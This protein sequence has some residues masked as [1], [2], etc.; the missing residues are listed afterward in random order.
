M[1]IALELDEVKKVIHLNITTLH[2]LLHVNH[3]IN[4]RWA[5]TISGDGLYCLCHNNFGMVSFCIVGLHDELFQLCYSIVPTESIL[6]YGQ[7]WQC[8]V[9]AAFYF[10]KQTKVCD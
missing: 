7:A 8:L 2:M 5:I 6:A 10:M 1:V 3:C 9:A 4:A